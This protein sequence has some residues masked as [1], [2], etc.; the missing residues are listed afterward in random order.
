MSAELKEAIELIVEKANEKIDLADLAKRYA[1]GEKRS[2]LFVVKGASSEHGFIIDENYKLKM[3]SPIERPTVIF[4]CDED[5]FWA[6]ASKKITMEYAF[7]VRRLSVTGPYALRD[8]LILNE[9]F[10]FMREKLGV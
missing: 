3:A 6:I 5:T 2:L 4:S 9:V 1:G 7:A 10:Q 8:F